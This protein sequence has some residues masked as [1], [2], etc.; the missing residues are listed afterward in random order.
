MNMQLNVRLDH[1]KGVQLEPNWA[2]VPTMLSQEISKSLQ[3]QQLGI[4]NDAATGLVFAQQLQVISNRVRER[5]YPEFKAKNLMPMQNE[6]QF[7]AE[8]FAYIIADG[9]GMFELIANYADDLPVTSIKGE[10]KVVNINAYGGAVIYS[11]F[12][13]AKATLAGQNLVDREMM[14]NRFQA[15]KKFDQIAWIGDPKA[16]SF[17]LYNAPNVTRITA[18]AGAGGTSFRDKTAEEI[19]ADLVAPYIQQAEDTYGAEVP[20]TKVLTSAAFA[21]ANTKRFT[22]LTGDT[23]MARFRMD[24]PN[25]TVDTV[26]WLKGIAPGGTDAMID[27]RNDSQK[28]GV[29]T[30]Q[31]YTV[32][33]PEPR[34]LATVVDA[35]LATAGTIVYFPLSV[36]VTEGI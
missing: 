17:G 15:E 13:I 26:D 8:E 14:N 5:A 16:G 33:P 3:A 6:A 34:N 11:I 7:G 20:D 1:L 27:Y 32:M 9:E 30:P 18:P 23:A 10:K 25:V 35:Y 12:D 36:T 19:Y 29:E 21:H 28:L 4:R 2:H 22:D 31:P 24:Y